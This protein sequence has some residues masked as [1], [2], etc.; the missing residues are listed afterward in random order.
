MCAMTCSMQKELEA[1]REAVLR[2][3]LAYPQVEFVLASVKPGRQ[4]LRLVK[5]SFLLHA[6]VSRQ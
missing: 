5:A 4:L 6:Y 1:C 3:A 2:L